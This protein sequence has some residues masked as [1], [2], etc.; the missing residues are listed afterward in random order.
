MMAAAI[1]AT[2][3]LSPSMLSRKLNALMTSTNQKTV[4]ATEATGP[5]AVATRTS[6]PI[7]RKSATAIS[8]SSLLTGPSGLTSSTNPTTCNTNAPPI[9]ASKIGSF[10]A[11]PER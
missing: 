11:I 4:N 2:P 3:A 7:A 10:S 8:T 6:Q 5:S 1:A 9:T